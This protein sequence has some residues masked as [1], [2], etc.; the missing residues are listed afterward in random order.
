MKSGKHVYFC[1]CI[2]VC[3]N[4]SAHMRLKKKSLFYAYI[5]VHVCLWVS[6]LIALLQSKLLITFHLNSHP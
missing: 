3:A 1:V 6:N 5:F 4:M 2:S